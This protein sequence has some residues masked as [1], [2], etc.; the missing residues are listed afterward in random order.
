LLPDVEANRFHSAA[1]ILNEGKQGPVRSL[2]AK[3]KG[4]DV[5][6]R[7]SGLRLGTKRAIADVTRDL[8]SE[9]ISGAR[10]LVARKYA[11]GVAEH[12]FEASGSCWQSTG[13]SQPGQRSSSNSYGEQQTTFPQSSSVKQDEAAAV[14]KTTA[15][16]PSGGD[17]GA[18]ERASHFADAN[19][20]HGNANQDATHQRNS[21]S[22]QD[23]TPQP[24]NVNGGAAEHASSSGEPT[25]AIGRHCSSEFLSSQVLHIAT[26]AREAGKSGRVAPAQLPA[27]AKSKPKRGA[28]E[29]PKEEHAC[30]TP[31]VTA[32]KS[33]PM[34]SSALDR[35]APKRKATSAKSAQSGSDGATP[36]EVATSL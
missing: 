4:W 21:G 34:M 12:T 31:K 30:K 23:V 2:C 14:I 11:G 32:S 10:G 25:D 9:V 24:G 8:A 5:S 22:N 35:D 28:T 3:K 27:R 36:P 20:Q 16:S 13:D 15:A 17:D 7:G 19:P 29:A 6:L 18:A 33:R 1:T 26:S